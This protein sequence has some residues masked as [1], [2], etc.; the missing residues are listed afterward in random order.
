MKKQTISVQRQSQT[1][2]LCNLHYHLQQKHIQV[3][4]LNYKKKWNLHKNSQAVKKSAAHVKNDS[5]K[6]LWNPRWWPRSGSDGRIMAKFLIQNIR[7]NLCASKF[8]RIFLLKILTITATSGPPPWISQLFHAVF[9]LYGPHLFLQFGCFCVDNPLQ[10]RSY[11]HKCK[12]KL[13]IL[14]SIGIILIKSKETRV[15]TYTCIYSSGFLIPN[16]LWH[17][18]VIGIKCPLEYLQL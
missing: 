13:A 2:C 6:K 16:S 14:Q 4:K 10:L 5:M 15:V 1:T 7:A 11:E 3:T 9:F 12:E 17:G 18:W 8:A